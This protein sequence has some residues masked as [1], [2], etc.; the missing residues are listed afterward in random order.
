MALNS[1][2]TLEMADD[3]ERAC[4]IVKEALTHIER[5]LQTNSDLAIDWAGDPKPEYIVEDDPV[6][7]GDRGNLS[8]KNYDRIEVS[9]SLFSLQQ[10]SNVLNDQTISTGDHIGNIN[11]V[12]LANP[13]TQ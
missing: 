7:S 5:V 4:N 8:G 10:V 6:V 2:R 11:K 1:R 9:N 12:A 3:I 13:T